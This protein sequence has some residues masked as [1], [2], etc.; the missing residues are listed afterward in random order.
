MKANYLQQKQQSPRN[1]AD[2]V[3]GSRL[4]FVSLGCSKALVDSERVLGRLLEEGMVLT[5]QMSAADVIVV[6]TCGFLESAE[7][8]SMEKIQEAVQQKKTGNCKYVVALGCL[9]DRRGDRIREQ[10]PGVD[11][12]IGAKKREKLN[13]A[14]RALLT[15]LKR[16][17]IVLTGGD[18]K[19]RRDVGRYRLTEPHFGYVKIG[20]GCD[21]TCT[22]CVIPDIRG[23]LQSKSLDDIRAEVEEL[24]EDGAREIVVIGQD[25]SDYGRDRYGNRRLAD[26]LRTIADVDGIE[27]VRLMYAY[28]GHLQTDAVQ[29]MAEHPDIV[30]YID[31][32][33]QHISPRILK[34]MSRGTTRSDVYEILE[35]LRDHIPNLAIRTT[36]MVG[37]PG[38][39]EEDFQML[40][41]FVR[42]QQF[43]RLGVFEY[44]D[45]QG[46]PAAKLDQKIDGDQ[47]EE[48]WHRLMDIQK[49]IA[50]Q[51]AQERIGETVDVILEEDWGARENGMVGRTQWDAPERDPVIYVEGTN[52]HRPGEIVQ[53]N[54]LRS[55]GYD[56]GGTVVEP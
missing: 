1:P 44:S 6:N 14:I 34:R 41:D 36:L 9:A 24:V 35:T 12:V 7:D 40:V 33:I 26:A 15:G 30:P 45:E 3:E 21:N 54:I 29:I 20:E 28:P 22:F 48:R 5:D 32:P 46:S 19:C 16:E 49:D 39:T 56:L 17:D 18:E 51:K 27:W 42:E 52:G 10:L 53:A 55:Q 25:T 43:D 23:K 37:F 2:G 13:G 4:A 11:A 8:E 31:M 50:F 47:K 38:E